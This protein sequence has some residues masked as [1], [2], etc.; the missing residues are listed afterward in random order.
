VLE[1]LIEQFHLDLLE[2]RRAGQ[3]ILNVEVVQAPSVPQRIEAGQ[4][5]KQVA[6]QD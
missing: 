2:R 3:T 6:E 1:H 4:T 5:T